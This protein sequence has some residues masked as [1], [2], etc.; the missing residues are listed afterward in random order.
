MVLTNQA[1]H[2]W[3]RGSRMGPHPL[4]C[5]PLREADVTRFRREDRRKELFQAIRR[6]DEAFGVAQHK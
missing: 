3:G 1:E 4:S 6:V 5:S 2:G